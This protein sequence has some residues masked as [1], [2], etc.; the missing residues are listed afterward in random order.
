MKIIKIETHL[1]HADLNQPFSFSQ[2]WYD[3]RT[4]C[5]VEITTDNGITGWGECYGPSKMVLDTIENIKDYLIGKDPRDIDVHWETLYNKYRDFGQKGLI[6]QAMSGIDIALWDI[7]GK[8]V[9]LPVHKLMGGS[10]R[11][12]VKAYATGFYPIKH[13]TLEELKKA[14]KVEAEEYLKQGF[15]AL[16]MKVGFGVKKD[17]EL[18][19]YVR[20][21][22]GENVELM[23]DANH[24]YD[25][26]EAIK[27]GKRI[28]KFDISW[29][30]EPVCPEDKKGYLE[31]KQ[32]L[33][34]PI[35]G[36]E[37]EFTRF[38]FRDIIETRAIDILQPDTC[39]AGGLSECKKIAIMANAAGV[40]YNPHAWGT[41]I[42]LAANL[43]LLAILPYNPISL[44]PIEP[45]LELDQTEHPFRMSLITEPIRHTNGIVQIP[46][47]PGLGIEINRK[48][49][50]KF[51]IN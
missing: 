39:S 28:E 42:G 44:N 30:E 4:A 25:T 17:Y 14:H 19:K 8:S 22:I 47:G 15:T 1:L 43:Q 37:A 29:F 11:T 20:E 9:N 23:I 46:N 40:R 48:V 36:G 6:I 5:I 21:L 34:I 7:F 32:N 45:M 16:K 50:M 12:K 10:M 2:W 13:E 24:A 38:G 49:L 26:V 31:C 33:N 18:V 3:T 35:A 51:K 41:G 27:L